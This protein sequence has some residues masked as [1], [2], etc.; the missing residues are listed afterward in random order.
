MILSPGFMRESSGSKQLYDI[1]T[2]ITNTLDD[3]CTCHQVKRTPYEN[4]L[5]VC[6]YGRACGVCVTV[7]PDRLFTRRG[8]YIIV[9]DQVDHIL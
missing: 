8:H 7:K 5:S 3:Y 2:I 4:R 6:A 1:L 9:E